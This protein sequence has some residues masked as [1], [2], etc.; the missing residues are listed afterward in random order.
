M[1]DHY[2]PEEKDVYLKKKGVLN[3]PDD[4]Q[5]TIFGHKEGERRPKEKGREKRDFGE[6]HFVLGKRTQEDEKEIPAVKG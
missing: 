5:E 4:R 6:H 1:V 3:W 2:R